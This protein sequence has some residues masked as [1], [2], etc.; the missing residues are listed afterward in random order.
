MARYEFV[1][2]KSSKF[3]EIHLDGSS[4]LVHYGRIG[5]TGQSQTKTF[6]TPELALKEHNKLVSEKTKKGY[7]PAGGQN[8]VASMPTLPPPNGKN[9]A[10]SDAMLR[11]DLYVYN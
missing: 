8:G 6:S 2:G 4:L 7:A 10:P 11:K 5:T 3:W 1:E 9:L